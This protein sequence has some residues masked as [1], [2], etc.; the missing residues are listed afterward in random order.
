MREGGGAYGVPVSICAV[1]MACQSSRALT[2]LRPLPRASY[3]VYSA[4][5][6]MQESAE[7]PPYLVV[8]GKP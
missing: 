7:Y 1:R 3:D 5:N 6:Y 4:S 8:N 2:A